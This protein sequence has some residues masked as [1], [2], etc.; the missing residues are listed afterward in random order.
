MHPPIN[1]K[2]FTLWGVGC[3]RRVEHLPSERLKILL[4]KCTVPH[5]T[6]QL[7]SAEQAEAGVHGAGEGEDNEPQ[8]VVVGGRG[9]TLL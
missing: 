5:K 1:V 3:G 7:E 9:R 6:A 2:Q 4:R 8:L